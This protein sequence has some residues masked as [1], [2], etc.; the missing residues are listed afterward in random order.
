MGNISSRLDEGGLLYLKDQARCMCI[1]CYLQQELT[2]IVSVSSI[3]VSNGQRKV[4]L[5]VAPNTYPATR[6][7][8]KPDALDYRPVSYIQVC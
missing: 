5:Y 4:L 3:V 6:L 2:G 1:Q 7:V 8:G